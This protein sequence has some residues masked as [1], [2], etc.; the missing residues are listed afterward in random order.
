M[1]ESPADIARCLDLE[2]VSRHT[3]EEFVRLA[4]EVTASDERFT[5]ALSGGSTPKALYTLLASDTFRVRIP[6]EKVH[7]FWDDERC[8]PPDHLDSN[9]RMVRESLLDHAPVPKDNIHRMLGEDGDPAKAATTYEATLRESF[10]FAS[11]QLPRF[12][13][14]LLGM[15]NDRHTASL[16]PRTA[17]LSE[18]KSLVVANYV[19]KF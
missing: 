17:A 6:W 2:D 1:K 16:F 7:L 14:I 19:E 3:V 12:D 13:L 4:N 18:T 11:G 15:G 9:Y 10:G 5:V 8:V